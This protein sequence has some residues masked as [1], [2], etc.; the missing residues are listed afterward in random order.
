MEAQIVGDPGHLDIERR[1]AG[2]AENITGAVVFRPFHGLDAAVMAVAAPHDAGIR[3]MLFQARRHMLDDGP[4]LRALGSARRAQDDRHRRA[5]RHV[6]DVHRRKAAL[7]V[8]RVPERQLLAAMGRTEGVVDIEDL[9][10][11]RLHGGAEL[12]EQ[13]R[14]EPRRSQDS[15][16]P[17]S[18]SA[19]R[20]AA[21]RGRWH[22]CARRQSPPPAPSPFRTSRAECGRNRDDP[23][24][25]PQAAG[26]RQ[27][28]APPPAAAAGRHRRTGCRRQNPL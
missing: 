3:P 22:P 4:H 5:A 13:S 6:I 14:G 9:H 8:M 11:A 20:A 16:R 21:G 24:S 7:V 23:A 27:A 26:I 1:I 18:S 15:G 19:D 25:L 2:E 12:I 28:C 17:L 10:L